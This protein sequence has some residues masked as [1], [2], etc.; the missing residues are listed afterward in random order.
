MDWNSFE[1][2]M[3]IASNS[4][5]AKSHNGSDL[6]SRLSAKRMELETQLERFR[7]A[8]EDDILHEYERMRRAHREFLTCYQNTHRLFTQANPMQRNMDFE[9]P[10][11]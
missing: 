6:L 7:Q 11:S 8:A 9:I 5:P 1:S 2:L 3:Q 4:T 10:L